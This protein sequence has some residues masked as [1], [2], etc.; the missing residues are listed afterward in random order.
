MSTERLFRPL[1]FFLLL[2]INFF[3][4]FYYFFFDFSFWIST[5][6][7]CVS[8]KAGNGGRVDCHFWGAFFFFPPSFTVR[9]PTF[10]F[11]F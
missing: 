7:C 10:F 2:G 8:P 1:V 11:T 3:S 4:S 9:Q 5:A 6:T